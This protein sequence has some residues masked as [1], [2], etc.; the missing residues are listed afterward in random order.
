MG[1]TV[2]L[3]EPGDRVAGLGT[4]AHRAP[5]TLGPLGGDQR[6]EQLGRD[7][8]EFLQ[9]GP[10]R[11][12]HELQACQLPGSGQDV[13]G[14]GALASPLSDQPGFPQ[15][16]QGEVEQSVGVVVL[17]QPVAEVAQHAVVEAGIVQ[18]QS[19]GVLEVKAAAHLLGNLTVG[20]VEQEL[21][22]ADGGQLCG[23]EPRSSVAGIPGHEVLVT[24]Q[25]IKP[26]AHPHR[27]RAL[28]VARPRHP[29]GHRRN[30]RSRTGTYGHRAPRREQRRAEHSERAR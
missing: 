4:Q 14:V 11:F 30:L 5:I 21:Q 20:Q 13:G 9:R 8:G 28:R 3:G 18:L 17:G 27:R 7:H 12:Q 25:A 24:P 23:R 26:V 2:G 19:Q 16:C 22:H 15:T 1:V 10:D 6:L 29:R